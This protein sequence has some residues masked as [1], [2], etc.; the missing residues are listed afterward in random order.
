MERE[1]PGCG[2]HCKCCTVRP[3]VCSNHGSDCPGTCVDERL[4]PHDKHPTFTCS[5]NSC[6]CC[7][8]PVGVLEEYGK[9]C[10]ASTH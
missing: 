2:H 9:R 5:G 6:T 7:L 4:C 8:T 10:P 3:A 1:V